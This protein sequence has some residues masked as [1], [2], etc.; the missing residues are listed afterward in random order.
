M[1]FAPYLLF[2]DFTVQTEDGAEVTAGIFSQLS[3]EAGHAYFMLPEG[4]I[5]AGFYE[6]KHLPLHAQPFMINQE[7]DVFEVMLH[8]VFFSAEFNIYNTEGQP[9]ENAVITFNNLVYEPGAY[10]F[11]GLQNGTYTYTV[12]ADGYL[13][14]S[15]EI[16]ILNQDVV[17]D[18]NLV[19]D[20]TYVA[21]PDHDGP[22]IYPN[23]AA[24]RVYIDFGSIQVE[25]TSVKLMTLNGEVIIS[26]SAILTQG[27]TLELPLLAGIQNGV[28]LLV[29]ESERTTM[30]LKL[31]ISK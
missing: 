7:G 9:V 3:D 11:E 2:T 5:Y 8:R 26:K 28:Y 21:N 22:N 31:V 10:L 25:K 20:D 13:N 12:E 30:H 23:P 17:V 14:T 15:S 24:D 16:E 29:I 27:N 6:E 1:A 4:E 19:P 18:V